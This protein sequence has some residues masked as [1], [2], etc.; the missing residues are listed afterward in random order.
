MSVIQNYNFLIMRIVLFS[1]VVSWLHF[2]MHESCDVTSADG[3]CGWLQF[4]L[5]SAVHA[6]AQMP[7]WHDNGIP[8]LAQTNQALFAFVFF[9]STLSY[10]ITT[11]CLRL[12][13]LV[14]LI[15]F[16][17]IDTLNFKRNSVNLLAIMLI[18]S[19]I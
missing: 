11:S 14:V 5:L 7:T 8:L 12:H 4:E 18:T 6:Y 1:F 9:W 2:K 10:I 15:W 13:Y 16:Q 19:S 3:T 17:S